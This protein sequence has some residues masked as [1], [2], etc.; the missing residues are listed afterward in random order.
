ML[1]YTPVHIYTVGM[2]AIKNQVESRV[3]I[4][5]DTSPTSPVPSFLPIPL[6]KFFHVKIDGSLTAN[7]NFFVNVMT[8]NIILRGIFALNI[9]YH[10]EFQTE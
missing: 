8:A 1:A 6:Y 2:Q 3:Q 7:S 10:L 4:R 9:M 5:P